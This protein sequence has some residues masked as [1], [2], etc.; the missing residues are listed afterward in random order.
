M[1]G[2]VKFCIS[3][4]N[5]KPFALKVSISSCDKLYELNLCSVL[6]KVFFGIGL[7]GYFTTI[8]LN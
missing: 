4:A 5:S 8:N 2:I 6:I 7:K 3:E 1:T